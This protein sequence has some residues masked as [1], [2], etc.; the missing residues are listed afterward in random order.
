MRVHLKVANWTVG[1]GRSLTGNNSPNQWRFIH[2]CNMCPKGGGTV[3]WPTGYPWMAV[4][5]TL[6]LMGMYS[7]PQSSEEGITAPGGIY[8][9]SPMWSSLVFSNSSGS[10]AGTVP[11]PSGG[12]GYCTWGRSRGRWFWGQFWGSL[13][14]RGALFIGVPCLYLA[15]HY[16]GL[17]IYLLHS[18]CQNNV[19]WLQY[20]T[21]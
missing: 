14:Y 12:L 10:G 20:L 19:K 8:T 18:S 7:T 6:W 11:P 4:P 16:H 2:G 13:V 3:L 5:V 21:G 9:Q 15:S 17:L 1:E